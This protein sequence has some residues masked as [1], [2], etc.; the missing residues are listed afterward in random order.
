VGLRRD[1]AEP[2]DEPGVVLSSKGLMDHDDVGV[3]LFDAAH[4]IERAPRFRRYLETVLFK[5]ESQE[6][7]QKRTPIGDDDTWLGDPDS[8]RWIQLLY[9]PSSSG[10]TATE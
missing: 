1:L 7:P 6:V 2:R 9:T 8:S 4:G 3:Q 10:N 5:D